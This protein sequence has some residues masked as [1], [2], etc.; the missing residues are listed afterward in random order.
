LPNPSLETAQGIQITGLAL[1]SRAVVGGDLF[2]A[3]AGARQHG[4]NHVAQAIDKGACGV[5]YDPAGGG[6]QLI[7]RANICADHCGRRSGLKA[8]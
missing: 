7:E 6:K 4:L 2:I 1:D 5:V 8:G 3:L